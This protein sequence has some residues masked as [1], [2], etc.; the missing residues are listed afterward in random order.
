MDAGHGAMTSVCLCMIVKDEAGVIER[1]LNSVKDLI[2][3]WV[4]CDTGSTDATQESIRR[5]LAGVPGEL[6]ER[7]WV[8]FSH[9]RT[10]LL[11]IARGKADY[12]LLLDA[13]W[14]LVAKPRALA[15]LNADAYLVRHVHP[16]G[17]GLELFNRHLV[18]ADIAWRYVG[19]AHEYITTGAATSEQRLD[20]AYIVNWADGGVGRARRW[21]QDAE[22]LEAAVARD[23]ADARSVFYLGQTYR[24]LGQT[25][26]AIEL[27]SRRAAMQGWPEEAFYSQYQVGVLRAQQGDWDVAVPALL[28][29]WS[30]RPTRIEPLYQLAAGYRAREAYQ[31]GHLFAARAFN[32]PQ[33]DDILFV[34]PWIYRWGVLFEYSITAYWVG[35]PTVA[36]NACDRLLRLHDL[37]AEY[38]AYTERNR[39][40]CLAKLGR[41]GPVAVKRG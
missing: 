19:V 9:N 40:F 23:P 36:L 24:D 27:Y 31:A 17:L 12:L 37:P 11:E 16:Q 34:E 10:E 13:D 33:P 20:D 8:G 5:T 6:H 18:R 41:S 22:L 29:A 38:R 28:V 7:P 30:L 15:R 4:I 25:D 14:T 26:R 35:D 2:S 21:Q 39:E 32:R 3:Y 1:C